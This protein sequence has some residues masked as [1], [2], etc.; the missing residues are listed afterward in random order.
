MAVKRW[1]RPLQYAGLS[2][3]MT[4][5][6]IACGQEKLTRTDAAKKISEAVKL[7]VDKIEIIGISRESANKTEVAAK[8]KGHAEI[9]E[10]TVLFKLWDTGWQVETINK[11]KPGKFRRH[12]KD[13]LYKPDEKDLARRTMSDM[14]SVGTAIESYQVDNGFP[15]EQGSS[16]N[17]DGIRWHLQPT[18]IRTLPTMDAWKNPFQYVGGPSK[19]DN[20][21]V[22]SYG[23]DGKY[24]GNTTE[25]S[26]RSFDND[27]VYSNG[28]FIIWPEGTQN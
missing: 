26:T 15:P 6:L 1:I 11:R 22:R 10:I 4:G 23:K 3:L 27:I 5:L 9:L 25:G 12:F 7:D 21:W 18:Y 20:Y 8:I 2:I 24:D 14:R 13:E 19:N 28:Q 16:G 17:V